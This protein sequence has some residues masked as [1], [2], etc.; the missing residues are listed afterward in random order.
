MR[1]FLSDHAFKRSEERS[2]S[3]EAINAAVKKG[4]EYKSKNYGGQRRF[5]H[6]GICVIVRKTTDTI[7]TC[8]RYKHN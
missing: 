6:E 2:I 5:Y 7:L 1:Y 8:Y 3:I 4:K